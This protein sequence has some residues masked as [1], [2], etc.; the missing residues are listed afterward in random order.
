MFA[1]GEGGTKSVDQLVVKARGRR[2]L[3]R[4]IRK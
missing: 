1:A 2:R 3:L 4:R